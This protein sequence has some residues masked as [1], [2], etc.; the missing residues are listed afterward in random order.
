MVPFYL[1]IYTKYIGKSVSPFLAAHI[2]QLVTLNWKW[3]WKAIN[4]MSAT[5]KNFRFQ[6]LRTKYNTT[7]WFVLQINQIGLW[8]D[9]QVSF[10]VGMVNEARWSS[11]EHTDLASSR[12]SHISTTGS[13]QHFLCG[14]FDTQVSDLKSFFYFFL[15][16][17]S[18]SNFKYPFNLGQL[19]TGAKWVAGVCESVN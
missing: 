3:S 2:F 5:Y 16:R 1:H 7:S 8:D 13:S 18:L 4:L 19:E 12:A 6:S 15:F 17:I 9:Y 14:T 10:W 11:L